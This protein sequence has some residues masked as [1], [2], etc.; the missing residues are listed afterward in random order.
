VPSQWEGRNF[1]PPQ[2]PH[3]STDLNETSKPK[4]M[5]GIR[6]QVQN[7]ADVGQREGGLR[8]G[9]FPLLFVF[10][11]SILFS[12]LAHAYRSHQKTDHDRLWLKTCV[13]A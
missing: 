9:H 13:S 8:R 12:I 5:P 1:E 4:K 7:L 2:L 3:F 10:Y 11:L 6:P